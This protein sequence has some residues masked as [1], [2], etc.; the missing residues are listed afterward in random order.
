MDCALAAGWRR[1]G[2]S[3]LDSWSR[4]KAGVEFRSAIRSTQCQFDVPL[5]ATV[6]ALALE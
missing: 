6:A 1:Q 4:H 5:S 2:T 3:D